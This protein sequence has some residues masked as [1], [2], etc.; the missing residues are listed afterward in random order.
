[1]GFGVLYKWFLILLRKREAKVFE[2]IEK[3]FNKNSKL[4]EG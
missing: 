1:L 2:E 4:E 3:G